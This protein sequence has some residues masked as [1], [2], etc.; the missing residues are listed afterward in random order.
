MPKMHRSKSCSIKLRDAAM[1][2]W[3]RR[4]ISFVWDAH[5]SY[6]S[7]YALRLAVRGEGLTAMGDDRKWVAYPSVSARWNIIDEDW[8]EWARPV[9]SMLS[10]RPGWGMDGHAPGDNK[11]FNSYSTF[12]QGSTDL[13]YLGMAAF[14]MDGIRLTDLRCSRKSEWN[15]G[16]DFGFFNGKITGAFNYYSGTTDD[17]LISNY[18]I[19]SPTGYSYLAYKNSGSVRNSGWEVN[20]NLNNL[21]LAKDFSMSVYFN[22]GKNYNEILELEEAYLED[23]N[24]KYDAP[25]NS[26]YLSRVQIGNPGGSIYG[27]RYKSLTEGSSN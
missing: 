21:K 10:I 1:T 20:L 23:R 2:K 4:R 24:G 19:P 15:I 9:V 27:F 11:T 22:V 14:Q 18:K 17:Q 6:K 8:M 16:S 5:Y 12:K 26:A 7:K 25:E 13:S 3:E